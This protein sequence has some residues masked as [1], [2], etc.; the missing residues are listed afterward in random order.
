MIYLTP[1]EPLNFYENDVE[2]TNDHQEED[3]WIFFYEPPSEVPILI[4]VRSKAQIEQVYVKSLVLNIKQLGIEIH[5]ENIMIPIN[6]DDFKNKSAT[7]YIFWGFVHANEFTTEEIR[8]AYSE[9]ITFNQLYNNFKEVNDVEFSTTILYEING[10]RK[11]SN[12]IWKFKTRRHTSI[13]IEHLL[14]L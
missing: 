11:E 3:P 6:N 8:N 13:I 9:K 10:E 5:K 1:E 14:S 12:F 4:T 7:G 2:F